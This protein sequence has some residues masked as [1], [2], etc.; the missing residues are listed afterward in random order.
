VKIP[1]RALLTALACLSI[2]WGWRRTGELQEDEARRALVHRL[3]DEG[4]V[5]LADA[6]AQRLE[7][8]FAD[9]AANVALHATTKV[10]LEANLLLKQRRPAD[11]RA[12]LAPIVAQ[13]DAPAAAHYLLGVALNRLGESAAAA[14]ELAKARALA[15]DAPLF[16]EAAPKGAA[17]DG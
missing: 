11:A 3:L 9:V 4:R 7:R 14:A 1:V 17:G 16:R 10:L 13:P 15:P 12:R 8:D 2:A 6:E 5:N